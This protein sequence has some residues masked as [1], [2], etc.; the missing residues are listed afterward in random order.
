MKRQEVCTLLDE[1]WLSV[2]GFSLDIQDE[3]AGDDSI[4]NQDFKDGVYLG[5]RVA[6]SMMK[7]EILR[8]KGE[9][10]A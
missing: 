6:S 10:L 8:R 2:Y 9:V 4:S 5:L 7:H 3:V 1:L